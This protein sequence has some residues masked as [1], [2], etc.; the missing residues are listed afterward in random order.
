MTSN[1]FINYIV[2][3]A[4]RHWKVEGAGDI[5]HGVQEELID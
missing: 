4:A 2:E 3:T 1:R 5:M